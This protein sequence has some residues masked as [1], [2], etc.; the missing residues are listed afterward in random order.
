MKRRSNKPEAKK[1][2]LVKET[3]IRFGTDD[4]LNFFF[5]MMHMSPDLFSQSLS[6]AKSVCPDTPDLY[7]AP[8]RLKGKSHSWCSKHFSGTPDLFSSRNCSP[9][10]QEL[11]SVSLSSCSNHSLLSSSS[12]PLRL[13]EQPV[14][15][16]GS[17]RNEPDAP[18]VINQ[19]ESENRF[20]QNDEQ[21]ISFHSKP[22][23]ANR[24]S[25]LLHRI[26]LFG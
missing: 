6:R 24:T 19:R 2:L 20:V 17:N 26:D 4:M 25:K 9:S 11:N 23:Y 18:S 14:S 5:E 12:S 1:L 7:S 10:R 3:V 15:S 22:C 8:R 16:S 21:A 13:V